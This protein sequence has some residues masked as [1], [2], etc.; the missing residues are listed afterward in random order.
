MKDKIKIAVLG[1]KGSFSDMAYRENFSNNPNI[2]PIYCN[3]FSG[4]FKQVD[5]EAAN[6]AIIPVYN[7]S[8]GYTKSDSKDLYATVATA[9]ELYIIGEHFEKVNLCLAVNPENPQIKDLT[10]VSNKNAIDQVSKYKEANKIIVDSTSEA[11]ILVK[12]SKVPYAAICSESTAKLYQLKIIEHDIQDFKNNATRFVFISKSPTPLDGIFPKHLIS[13]FIIYSENISET[14][15]TL[16]KNN[17]E[18]KFLQP[19]QGAQNHYILEISGKCA[20][21]SDVEVRK[22]LG[23]YKADPKRMAL[24]KCF[25][26]NIIEHKQH[27]KIPMAKL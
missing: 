2:E 17:L 26:N 7:S 21:L 11:A 12:K 18:I 14:Q 10:I 1:P 19:L 8:I 24:E 20:R 25:S 15:A 23:Y 13:A 5:S 6:I 9:S 22:Q 27:L 16:E 3:S 4:I